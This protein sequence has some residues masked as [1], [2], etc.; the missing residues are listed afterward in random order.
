MVV[1]LGL[2]KLIDE[3]LDICR[4]CGKSFYRATAAN[5]IHYLLMLT[6]DARVSEDNS[7]ES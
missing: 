1:K 2:A 5:K 4:K 3:V 6:E 7:N